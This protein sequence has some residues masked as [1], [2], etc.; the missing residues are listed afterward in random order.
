MTSATGTTDCRRYSARTFFEDF[1]WNDRRLA[2]STDI[3]LTIDRKG[4]LRGRALNCS[5]VKS[6]VEWI[7]LRGTA[8]NGELRIVANHPL[9]DNEMHRLRVLFSLVQY[10]TTNRIAPLLDSCGCLLRWTRSLL[11]M[12]VEELAVQL[13]Q[14]VNT[15][16]Q[17]EELSAHTSPSLSLLYRWCHILDLVC[18]P[19]TALVRGVDFSPELLRFLQ[20]DPSRLRS[21]TPLAIRASSTRHA[22]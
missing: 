11:H 10:A 7:G 6:D 18:P 19:K 3:Q 1:V 16:V 4:D 8:K 14:P 12:S 13:G 20:E 21:L 2:E 22:P 17:W 9:S 5:I 15:I